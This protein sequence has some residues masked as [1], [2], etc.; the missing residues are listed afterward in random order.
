MTSRQGDMISQMQLFADVSAPSKEVRVMRLARSIEIGEVTSKREIM[1]EAERIFEGTAASGAWSMRNL[2][3]AGELAQT[4]RLA[5]L[6]LSGA[7]KSQ[8]KKAIREAD[9]WSKSLPSQTVRTPKQNEL[10]QFSTP[11]PYALLAAYAAGIT[12]NTRILEPSA[13]TGLLA[14]AAIG[15][16]ARSLFVN[17]VDGKR[18]ALLSELESVTKGTVEVSSHDARYIDALHANRPRPHAVVMNPPFSQDGSRRKKY[19]AWIEHIK[20]AA[21]RLPKGGRL[22]AIIPS[23]VNHDRV[24]VP[25]TW[26]EAWSVLP[27]TIYAKMQIVA[28]VFVEGSIYKKHGTTFDTRLVVLEQRGQEAPELDGANVIVGAVRENAAEGV[29]ILCTV[30]RRF[31]EGGK[32]EK[33]RAH[34]KD[35][36]HSNGSVSTH[37]VVGRKHTKVSRRSEGSGRAKG[38]EAPV[39]QRKDGDESLFGEKKGIERKTLFSQGAEEGVQPKHMRFH[40]RAIGYRNIEGHRR[41]A[42][43]REARFEPYTPSIE[44]FGGHQHPTPL[45]ESSAMGCVKPPPVKGTARTLPKNVYEGRLSDAQIEV[46][47]RAAQA[48]RKMM[49]SGKRMGFMVGDGTGVGKG[50]EASAIIQD[51]FAHGRTKAIWLTKTWSLLR[52][53]RRDWKDIGGRPRDVQPQRQYKDVIALEQGILLTTYAT[54]RSEPQK[55][56]TRLEQIIEWAGEGFDGVIILDEA[57]EAGNLLGIGGSPPSKQALA[58]E[59]LQDLLPD[60]RIVYV[61]AT[62]ASRV[63]NLAYCQRLGLWGE[64][65]PFTD[66]EAFTEQ[67]AAGGVAAMELVSRDLKAMGLYASRTLSYEGVEYDTLVHK[68]TPYQRDMYDSMGRA[69]QKVY[70]N[71]QKV[72][73]A[74]EAEK[75]G[76]RKGSALAQ[77]WGAQQRFY[78]QVLIGLSAPT[79]IED[80]EQKIEHGFSPVLQLVNTGEAAQERAVMKVRK[81]GGTLTEMDL[82]LTP[83]SILMHYVEHAMPTTQMQRVE[84]EHGNVTYT[85]LRNAEGD[86]VECPEARR[87]R[88]ETLMR[89]S[90][91][92][93]GKSVL[94]QV[95]D[96]F[97][98]DRV[99]EITGR[100]RR[101][102]KSVDEDGVVTMKEERRTRKTREAERTEFQDGK[103]DILIF[104]EAGG[105][106]Q[107]YHAGRNMQNRKRR[108][109]YLVQAG[110]QAKKCVQGFGRTHRSNQTEAPLYL[111]VCTNL[112]AQKRFTSTIARRLAQLGA[113][114]QGQEDAASTGVISADESLEN[115]YGRE[116]VV[117]LTFDVVK[118]LED[119]LTLDT[120]ENRMG[121]DILDDDGTIKES[122][123]PTIQRFL[124]R[125]LSLTIERQNQAFE[126]LME[127]FEW[128]VEV[129][130]RN[131]T[132]AQGMEDLDVESFTVEKEDVVYTHESG[133]TTSLIKG[134]A[135]ITNKRLA[136][137]NVRTEAAS[138]MWQGFFVNRRS[139]YIYGMKLIGNSQ[140][141]EGPKMRLRRYGPAQKD[142]LEVSR[143][144]LAERYREISNERAERL[145]KKVHSSINRTHKA[146]M[147]LLTGA[148]VPV[149]DR[150]DNDTDKKSTVYKVE[151]TN[152]KRHLGRLIEKVDVPR[153]LERMGAESEGIDA[154]KG[155]EMIASGDAE[156]VHLSNGWMIERRRVQYEHRIEV[157]GPA[158]ADRDQLESFGLMA[159]FIAHNLRF[160]IPN[161]DSMERVVGRLMQGKDVARVE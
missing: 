159:E 109:H 124:N 49:P 141:E 13:G 144:E 67:I 61:S 15:A 24:E 126:A 117:Q 50:R 73:E 43:S 5:G 35:R 119:R 51:N 19:K 7:D 63:E 36:A 9:E 147:H 101:F 156:R 90:G 139:D 123:M 88:D 129:A 111:L 149:W 112:K 152:G 103:R 104:S 78:E 8:W 138:I 69:W 53:A 57:H 47:V 30:H 99:A 46:V 130:K 118:Q 74:T 155:V 25:E 122:K 41:R 153:L 135:E 154:V 132:Y 120:F 96:H 95:V 39:K 45:V 6:G 17:E 2:Y 127:R 160:F 133:A 114:T 128:S 54:L 89:L 125:M 52:D 86:T 150:L 68:L 66:A 21:K 18:A 105:T 136:W 137:S 60:A 94:D 82:D 40:A 121:L 115:V 110:W 76:Q 80:M 11:S 56:P 12:S 85:P 65:T 4:I 75:D 107:S 77:F 113:L 55:G 131:G 108:A 42:A 106:G 143:Q 26:N 37:K 140:T 23:G 10:N 158:Y 72:L 87:I 48:H 148:L 102:I 27:L 98:T 91:L 97:G 28:E 16:G 92:R 29:D 71:L 14:G 33:E 145:W 20:S 62:G 38:P 161:G 70:A 44:V 146:T 157:R 142:I 84:D 81:E 32:K 100:R 134:T 151:D 31:V 59:A 22:V 93:V 83:K 79:L 58:V 116:A 1:R 64:G 3:D 34:S